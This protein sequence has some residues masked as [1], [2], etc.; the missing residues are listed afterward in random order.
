MP[1]AMVTLVEA[2]ANASGGDLSLFG[3]PETDGNGDLLSI[4]TYL[5]IIQEYEVHRGSLLTYGTTS[6]CSGRH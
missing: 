4:R 3:G 2:M 1:T 5:V 6:E